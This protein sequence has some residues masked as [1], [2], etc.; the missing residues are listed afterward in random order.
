MDQT[1]QFKNTDWQIMFLKYPAMYDLQQNIYSIKHKDAERLKIKACEK[2][3][4]SN[5][6]RKLV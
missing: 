2:F 3:Y 6:K 1:Q 5:T 4:Q